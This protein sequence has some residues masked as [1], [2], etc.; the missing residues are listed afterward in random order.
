MYFRLSAVEN[1]HKVDH[2]NGKYFVHHTRMLPESSEGS[3]VV[4]CGYAHNL[5]YAVKL[6]GSPV[7]RFGY[8]HNLTRGAKREGSPV[9]GFDYVSNPE[10]AVKKEGSPIARLSSICNLR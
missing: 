2:Q 3:P 5:S 1:D 4:R 8:L 9:V 10:C 6:E 7:A